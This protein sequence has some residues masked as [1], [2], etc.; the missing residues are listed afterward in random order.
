MAAHPLHPHQAARWVSAPFTYERVGGSAG[1]AQGSGGYES[2]SRSQTL[3]RHDFDATSEDLMT[4]RAHE[5]AGLRASVS[6]PRAEEGTVV[7]M[8]L[9][10]GVLSLRIPCRIVYVVDEPR[11]RGFAYCTLPGHPESGEELF[12]LERRDDERIVFTITGFSKPATVAA[13]LGGP[14]TRRL[15]Q[16]MTTRY[17]RALDRLEA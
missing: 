11:R 15:Q 8:R 9:G 16:G 10:V 13:R 7:L 12:L 2:F 5:R 17:L 1:R 14:I 3:A 6:S 4:W